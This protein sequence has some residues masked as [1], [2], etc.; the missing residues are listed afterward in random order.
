MDKLIN[1]D[2][3]EPEG[4][5][6]SKGGTVLHQQLSRAGQPAVNIQSFPII[7]GA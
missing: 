4:Q 3:L 6:L 5:K 1:W 2:R 7:G